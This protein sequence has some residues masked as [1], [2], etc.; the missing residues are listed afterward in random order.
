MAHGN[1]SSS[2]SSLLRFIFHTHETLLPFIYYSSASILNVWR[3]MAEMASQFELSD[4][5]E[6]SLSSSSE[7]KKVNSLTR[8]L[9]SIKME[10][11]TEFDLRRVLSHSLSQKK[12]IESKKRE[13][14]IFFYTLS[15]VAQ[16]AINHTSGSI[17]KCTKKKSNS[18]LI[19]FH[20][21]PIKPSRLFNTYNLYLTKSFSLPIAWFTCLFVKLRIAASSHRTFHPMKLSH[22]CTYRIHVSLHTFVSLSSKGI[23][24][25]L[26]RIFFSTVSTCES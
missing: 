23:L 17:W 24:R 3:E 12:L 14:L 11:W 15:P 22:M 16:P 25:N 9:N 19:D 18:I 2:S 6:W 13:F 1:S 4:M 21:S 10:I 20:F 26:T 7:K 8:K 5:D